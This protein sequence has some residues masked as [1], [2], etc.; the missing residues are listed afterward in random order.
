M[1]TRSG[2]SRFTSS[3]AVASSASS[4]RDPPTWTSESCAT[5]I[6][7]ETYATAADKASYMPWIA[8]PRP[9]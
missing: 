2:A 9:Q 4:K 5:S 8:A 3:I 1:T 7:S 6:A